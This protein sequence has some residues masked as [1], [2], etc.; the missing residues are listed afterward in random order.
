VRQIHNLPRAVVE[1]RIARPRVIS[2]Q[3]LPSP[4]HIRPGPRRIRRNYDKWNAKQQRNIGNSP[5]HFVSP[6][7]PK[8][9]RTPLQAA[10]D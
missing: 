10:E 3:E 7:I 9:I 6:K 8:A 4:V 1:P 5:Q 2:E